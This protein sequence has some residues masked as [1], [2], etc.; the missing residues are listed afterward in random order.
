M[1]QCLLP[2]QHQ[3]TTIW[4][5]RRSDND[6]TTTIWLLHEALKRYPNDD[7]DTTMMWL[8]CDDGD[9]LFDASAASRQWLCAL[10]MTTMIWRRYGYGDDWLLHKR[11]Q[12]ISMLHILTTTIRWRVTTT[13]IRRRYNVIVASVTTTWCDDDF[14]VALSVTMVRQRYDIIVASAVTTI[15]CCL[16]NE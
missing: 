16:C 14:I 11:Q 3:S 8:Y 7:D 2:P 4:L 1:N 15:H 12:W 13:M 6:D 5:L 9:D 10:H